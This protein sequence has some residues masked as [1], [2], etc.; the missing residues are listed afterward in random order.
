MISRQEALKFVSKQ[1]ENK[2]I[3]KHMLAAEVCMIALARKLQGDEEE[4]GLTGLLHDADYLP[5]VPEE[6]QGVAVTKMLREQ[7]FEIPDD[8]AHAMAAHNAMTGVTPVSKMDW[9]IFCCDTLTGL[10]VATTLVH[11]EKKLHNITVES[12]MKKF[13][14]KSFA[15]GTRRADIAMC[16]EKLGI[17]LEEFVGICL[18]AMQGISGEIGL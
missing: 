12:V 6:K 7:G 8:I 4:W 11:P 14:D 1:I 10:I 9:A 3:V 13:K 15:A 16:E 17:P 18:G 2:N 5:S